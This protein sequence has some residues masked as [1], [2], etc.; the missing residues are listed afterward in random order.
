[1]WRDIRRICENP[2][3]EDR[4]WFPD[5]AGSTW[6]ETFEFA[7]HNFKDGSF[8][9]QYVDFTRFNRHLSRSKL[10]CRVN[11]DDRQISSAIQN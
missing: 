2:T 4:D 6:R 10:N 8:I 7:M 1:M 3:A 11:H 5:I 9:A